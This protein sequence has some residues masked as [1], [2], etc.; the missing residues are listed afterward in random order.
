MVAEFIDDSDRVGADLSC[1]DGEILKQTNLDQRIF[2]DYAPG[3]EYTGPIERTIWEIPNVDVF[4]L[5][6]TIEHLD[7]PET[8][9]E[10]IRLK[11]KK[12]ILSTPLDEQTDENHEHYWSFS[13]SDMYDLLL[14]T[15][16]TVVHYRETNP[17]YGYRFQIWG[18]T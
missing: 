14:D 7:D 9:L 16:F 3:Y 15:G 17:P 18:C 12:L 4:F 5:C 2:G 10:T 11:T 1:G 13:K 6:E 8:I